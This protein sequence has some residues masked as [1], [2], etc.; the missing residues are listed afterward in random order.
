MTKT[1]ELIQRAELLFGESITMKSVVGPLRD[2]NAD[3][4]A[5]RKWSVAGLEMHML[6]K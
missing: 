6:V 4:V 3:G 2:Q 1:K 5:A